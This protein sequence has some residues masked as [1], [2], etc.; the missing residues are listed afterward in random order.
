MCKLAKTVNG[1]SDSTT[2]DRLFLI[3]K[4]MFF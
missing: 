1:L 3:N 4:G 2:F